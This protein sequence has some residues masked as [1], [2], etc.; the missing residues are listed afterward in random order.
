MNVR[1][2]YERSQH[3]CIF[4]IFMMLCKCIF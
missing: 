4:C 1:E 2:I 3:L